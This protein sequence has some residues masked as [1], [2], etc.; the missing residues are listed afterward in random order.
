MRDVVIIGVGMTPFG[1]FL[2]KSLNDLGLVAVWNAIRDANVPPKDIEVAYVG[3]CLAGLI[4]GQ[5][6]IRGQ[7]ILNYAGFSGLPIVNVENAC[8]TGGTALKGAWMEVALGT[9]DVALA[10]GVEKMYLAD[11][12]KSLKAMAGASDIELANTG[13]QFTAPYA[14]RVSKYM[15]KYGATKEHF[16]K[17]VVKNSY[18]GS[19]NPYAQYR[20]PLSV[21]DVLNSR[22]VS[23]PLHLYMCC[24]IGDG[25]AAAI[26]CT[27]EIAKKYTDKPLAHIAAI[28]LRSGMI[29]PPECDT[30]P[31]IRTLTAGKAY[32]QAGIGP[33]DIDVA[34]IH[35]AMAPA[36]I[37]RYE[38]FGFCKAGEGIAMIEEGRTSLTGDIP[39]N[40]SGGLVARGHPVAATGLAQVAEIVWQFRGEAGERQ[41]A[42]PKV[43]LCEDSG[44][45]LG[46]DNAACC[47]IILKK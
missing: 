16:A 12:A 35:D 2:D 28:S 31:S 46:E 3:N 29:R 33:E 4:T 7:V 47:V 22:L 21:D 19:L 44:G 9:H 24:S 20:K 8:A 41:V 38:E 11:T 23:D 17:V 42:N 6:G 32:E 13:F 26:V 39:V 34:E 40:P 18:N 43:G 30:V 45:W 15:K 37:L 25:A 10:L 36:E 14:F 27:K 5:E 1:K